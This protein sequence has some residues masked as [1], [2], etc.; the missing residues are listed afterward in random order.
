MT[1]MKRALT[2]SGQILLVAGT[3]LAL[4][5]V[6]SFLMENVELRFFG[7]VIVDEADRA[8]WIVSSASAAVLGLILWRSFRATDAPA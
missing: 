3:T 8:I 6:A 4:G 1:T 2:I 7:N 5:G